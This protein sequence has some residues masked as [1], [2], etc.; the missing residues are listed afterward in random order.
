ML[1][2]MFVSKVYVTCVHPGS[3]VTSISGHFLGTRFSVLSNAE[4]DTLGISRS[5]N[6]SDFLMHSYHS[7]KTTACT[8]NS[9]DACTTLLDD[10]MWYTDAKLCFESDEE[11]AMELFVEKGSLSEA[12]VEAA[13]RAFL[14][15][16]LRFPTEE[17]N[18]TVMTKSEYL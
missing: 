1:Y 9:I 16:E 7:S 17:I 5:G 15:E 12:T 2:I 11:L 8:S 14:M 3:H 13:L 18:V 10:C 4:C 6:D